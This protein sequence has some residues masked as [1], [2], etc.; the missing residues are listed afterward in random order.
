MLVGVFLAAGVV[1]TAL[2]LPRQPPAELIEAGGGGIS[3]PA[4]P[5]ASTITSRRL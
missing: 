5:N 1:I 3:Q 2:G 4:R